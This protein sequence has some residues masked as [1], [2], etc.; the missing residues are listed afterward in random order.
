M[1]VYLS[2]NRKVN[3]MSTQQLPT[4]MLKDGHPVA[5]SQAIAADF[6][7]QHKDVLKAI[8]N[9]EC[10]EAFTKRNF[11]LC[12]EN[13]ELQ[14]GK[15]QPF[16]T[17]TRDGF[18]FLCMGFTGPKA[19]QWKEWYIAAF[20][21]MEARLRQQPQPEQ[22]T[23]FDESATDPRLAGF[24]AETQR[25]LLKKTPR[26][27]EVFRLKQAG[28]SMSRIAQF[29]D[30]GETTIRRASDVLARCGFF[31]ADGLQGGAQ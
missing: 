1:A 29:L 7:K 20:N 6:G 11:A 15:P 25:Q 2:F 9:L 24:L 26:L 5:T 21:A 27:A 17:M 28:F 8:K 16:Y 19:A 22:F 13:S 12:F 3:T 14:N 31:Y 4:L 18:M 10:S 30:V 23:L